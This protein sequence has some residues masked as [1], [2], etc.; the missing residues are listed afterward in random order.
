MKKHDL[1]GNE[2]RERCNFL[3]FKLQL[4]TDMWVLRELEL[5]SGKSGQPI[6]LGDKSILEKI[7][8]VNTNL[9]KE[10]PQGNLVVSSIRP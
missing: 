10:T 1:K 7:D 3:S 2:W 5:N 4:I 6:N 9:D 8:S